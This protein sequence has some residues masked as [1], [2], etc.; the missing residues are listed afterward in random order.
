MRYRDSINELNSDQKEVVMTAGHCLTIACPGSGKSKTIATKAAMLLEETDGY[1]GAVTFSKD[2]AI[3]LRERILHL[4]SPLAAKRLIIGTFHGLAYKQLGSKIDIASEGDRIQYIRNAIEDLGITLSYKD[5]LA[6]I[7]RIKSQGDLPTP[8]SSHY[9]IF[10]NYQKQLEANRKI[11]FSDMVTMSLNNME[12][13]RSEPYPFSHLLVDEFQDTDKMQFKWIMTHFKKGT[14]VT[15]VGDDDQSIYG[16][17]SAL[18]IQG[19]DE[20]K[21]Q[22]H[23]R[24]IILGINYRSR[25]EILQAADRLIQ[26][27]QIRVSKDLVANKTA[28][29]KIVSKM[30]ATPDAEAT[31]IADHI[32]DITQSTNAVLSRNNRDLDVIESLFKASG[33][34]YFRPADKSLFSYAE[35]ALYFGILELLAGMK[36]DVGV[37][38]IFRF[39]DMADSDRKI[40]SGLRLNNF[41]KKSK[42]EL[43]EE[44]VSESGATIYRNFATHFEEWKNL[45]NRGALSLMIN[46][47]ADWLVERI[48]LKKE[49]SRRVIHAACLAIDRLNDDIPSRIRFLKESKNNSKDEHYVLLSTFH[50]SK[51]LEWDNVYLV[52]SEATICPSESTPLEEER[53]LYYVGTTRAREKLTITWTAK[54]HCS[55]FISE[56]AIPEIA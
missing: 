50:G 32:G 41:K 20:F 38:S 4:C 48:P 25:P 5:A 27:N 13:G 26:F 21:S 40:L 56:L 11:D 12:T 17:R 33:I 16:F 49:T 45:Y 53:R 54:N 10:E 14:I 31:Y 34:P 28:G 24:K 22:T 7:D 36:V 43:L 47:V 18:G 8:D 42:A 23:A 9:K 51:G 39:V 46:G 6:E 3:E 19:M 44:G 29:G 37:D 15:V 35:V 30:F 52:R 55:Q 1:I 2:A